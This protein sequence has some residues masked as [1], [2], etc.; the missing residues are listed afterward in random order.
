[1]RRAGELGIPRAEARRAASAVA[2]GGRVSTEEGGVGR[3]ALGAL[4]GRSGEV[5]DRLRSVRLG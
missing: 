4:S 3:P 5:A 2:G 1:M